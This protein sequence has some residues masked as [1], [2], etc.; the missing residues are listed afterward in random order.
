MRLDALTRGDIDSALAQVTE[1]ATELLRVE[2]ASVWR[3][4]KHALSIQCLDLYERG[5][6]RHSRGTI[7]TRE[8]APHYFEALMRERCIAADDARTDPRTSQFRE[9]YLEPLGIGAMLDAPV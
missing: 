3:F 2:R 7:I 9:G 6:A 5:P 4:D 8:Q 1:L